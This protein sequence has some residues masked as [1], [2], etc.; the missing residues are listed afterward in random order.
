MNLINKTLNN[1]IVKPD[2]S[3]ITTIIEA[4]GSGKPH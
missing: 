2:S 4:N 1:I 3:T